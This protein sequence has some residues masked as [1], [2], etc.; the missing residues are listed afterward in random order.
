M[1]NDYVTY[2]VAMQIYSG[3]LDDCLEYQCSLAQLQVLD[4][5]EQ[6]Q[7][8]CDDVRLTESGLWAVKDW[9]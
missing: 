1:C 2:I 5:E 9:D 3:R 7:C 8:G 6:R 4:T